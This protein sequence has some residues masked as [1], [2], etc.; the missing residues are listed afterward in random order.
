MKTALVI[1]MLNYLASVKIATREELSRLL[2]VS[3]RSITEYRKELEDAG[4][5]ICYKNGAGGGYYLKGD[6]ILVNPKLKESE[7]K[8]LIEASSYLNG[9]YD[10]LNKEE[11]NI[12]L[13]KVL[14]SSYISKDLEK[15]MIID[16]FPLVMSD[17]EIKI[18]YDILESSLDE[19]KKVSISYLS[20]KNKISKHIIH[21]Y[22]LYMYNLA[23]YVLAFNETIN[24]FGYFKL[25]RIEDIQKLKESYT[26]S[27]TFNEWDY[28]DKFGM[29]NNGEYYSISL[30]LKGPYAALVKERY[31]GK[32][33]EIISID[34]KTTILNVD[35]QNLS[36]I[37]S[38]IL[39]FGS[40]CKVLKPQI[41]KDEL[42]KELIKMKEGLEQ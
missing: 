6:N 13:G 33:Q 3:P 12:A 35:M 4:Y 7:K 29:K 11:F 18:R 15:P 19:L 30:E 31:Y 9:R 20:S 26:I 32:N 39:G 25:N 23:W 8:A 10:F 17:D 34:D 21:P 14:N 16:R 22:K 37:K 40:Y 38:F 5:S 41:I 2:E 24:D 42:K 1:K 27:L 28:L 36:N